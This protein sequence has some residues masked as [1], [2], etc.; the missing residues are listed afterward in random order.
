MY[1]RLDVVIQAISQLSHLHPFFGITFLVCK[2]K[3]LPVG[4]KKAF[5][6][7]AAEEEFLRKHYRPDLSSK[8]YFKPFKTSGRS[9]WLATKYASSGS[10]STRTRGLLGDAFI[11]DRG[12]NLWG[13]ESNYIEVLRQKLEQDRSGRVPAFWL[14]AWLYRNRN[15]P[16]RTRAVNIVEALFKEFLITRKGQ[17]KLFQATI[18]DL[19]DPLLTD[20]IFQDSKMLKSFT[21]APDAE[22]EEGGTLRDL[23]LKNVG[24]ASCLNFEPADRLSIITGDNGLGKTFILECVWWSLTGQ[25]AEREALPQDKSDNPSITF[26]IASQSGPPAKTTIKFD[27]NTSRWPVP[28]N[29]P[30]I[31]GLIVYARVDGSFAVW[32]PARRYEDTADGTSGLL[33]FS[34]DAVLNGLTNKIEGLIRDWV[35]WQNAKD[36]L[37][38]EMF[39]KVLDRLSPPDMAPLT[40][41]EP[42]RMPN[43]PRDIPTLQHSYGVVPFPNESA[44]VRRITTIAYL[45]VWAWNEHRIHSSLARKP[46]QTSIVIMVDEIEAHLHPKWQRVVLPALL[47]VTN[48][49]SVE[50]KPQ[51]IVATHSPMILA[52]MEARFS[53]SAD[54]LFHLYPKNGSD[55]QM[56]EV[57]YDK[58]GTVDA[59]LTSDVFELKQP[60]SQEGEAALEKAKRLLAKS[61]SDRHEIKR[62]HESLRQV[63][64]AEDQFWPRWLHFMEMKGVRI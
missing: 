12:T 30:T 63:L 16:K 32:D 36:Q 21:P 18:P 51:M 2:Q 33:L 59:W 13:W 38:F 25:W 61:S 3:R 29:R 23:Q 19:P 22:P 27:W 57:S 6:I 55:I 26:T 64:P 14:A 28:K 35:R 10:Q 9:R 24:P 42:I 39:C 48:L 43:D 20:E 8:Y 50:M 15:W 49:L 53:D 56:D 40:P 31:P 17:E 5:P 37:S 4:A 47:D 45:L 44:G 7:N 58:H 62:V 1:L 34:R 54:K 52:S 60:R 11:H 46:P 41:G